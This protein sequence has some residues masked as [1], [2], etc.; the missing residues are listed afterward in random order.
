MGYIVEIDPYDK[1][2]RPRSAPRWA[3]SRTRARPSASRWPASRWPCT[4]ATTRAASTSTS[5]S[6]AANW[7]AADANAADRMATGDK[8][9]DSGKLYVAKF[10]ADGTRPVGR[11]VASATRRSPA[12]PAMP[13]PTRPTCCV[14]ARLAA[15]AVGATKMD[16]P[17]WCA[18]Q[19]G[20]RRD[21]LHADQQQQPPRRADRHVA[22]AAGRRQPARLHRHEGRRP[23]RA[24]T[25]TAT[26]CA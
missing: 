26:S 4:W 14:N 21:L 1:T 8:Y 17:E 20:Q 11:A 22:A 19:P 13:S 25:R 5:S 15:D 7:D 12:T 16:R 2:R 18:V 9:L 6:P 10:N 23:R 3:A 24:A